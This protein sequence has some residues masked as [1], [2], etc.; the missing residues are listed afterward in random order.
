M[1]HTHPYLA[2]EKL[3]VQEGTTVKSTL[4]SVLYSEEHTVC[5]VLRE[6]TVVAPKGHALSLIFFVKIYSL[7]HMYVYD[8]INV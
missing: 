2:S 4:S 5:R 1:L 7:L 8:C 6:V 3:Q